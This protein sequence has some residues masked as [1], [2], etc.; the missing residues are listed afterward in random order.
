MEQ[1]ILKE[2]GRTDLGDKRRTKRFMEIVS[3][4]S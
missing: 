4:L 2:L 3:N 1:W